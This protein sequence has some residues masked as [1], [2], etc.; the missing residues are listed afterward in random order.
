MNPLVGAVSVLLLEACVGTTGGDVVNFDATASGTS[1]TRAGMDFATELGW[2]VALNEAT[3]HVGA[4]YL[5]E[6]MPVSGAQPTDCIL[7][8]TYVAEV[9]E[10]LDINLL[11]PEPQ[12]FGRRGTGTTLPALAGEVWLVGGDINQVQDSTPILMIA[13][14]ADKG[15][16]AYPFTGTITISN[17]RQ[18]DNTATSSHPICKERIVTP[19]PVDFALS[20][21][22]ALRLFVDPTMLFT[23]VDFSQLAANSTGYV[24]KDDSNDQPSR[25]LYL[26]L[27]AAGALYRFEWDR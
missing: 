1:D 23:N 18:P 8:G 22:G 10:G 17:N 13:G 24:F 27:K 14:T 12:P 5:N 20:P 16:V 6:S 3:L 15:A 9:T 21:G 19:I 4:V 2:H 25:N 11:S 7:P 26:N